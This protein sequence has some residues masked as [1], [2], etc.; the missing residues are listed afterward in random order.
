MWSSAGGAAAP[1][2]RQ[3]DREDED[4]EHQ[5]DHDD[6]RHREVDEAPI[7]RMGGVVQVEDRA[8]HT[9]SWI[10]GRSPVFLEVTC[11]CRRS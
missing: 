10:H 4:E 5:A 6:V 3:Q 11:I 2:E 7:N 9:S 8:E 1:G